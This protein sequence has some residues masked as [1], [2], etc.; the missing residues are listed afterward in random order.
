MENSKFEIDSLNIA[1]LEY[2]VGPAGSSD[3]VGALP[4][5]ALSV[6]IAISVFTSK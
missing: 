5:V 6:G 3:A 2:T 1:D 4:C